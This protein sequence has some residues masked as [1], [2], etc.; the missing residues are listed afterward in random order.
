MA[1]CPKAAV[2]FLGRIFKLCSA[3]GGGG[4]GLPGGVEVSRK[5]EKGKGKRGTIDL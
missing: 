1:L 4:E 3:K 2:T 5:E